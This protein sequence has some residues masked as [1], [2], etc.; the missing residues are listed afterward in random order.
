MR[1]IGNKLN[2]LEFIYSV[3]V[4]NK[5]PKGTLLDIFSG[6]TNVSKFFK[7]KGYK[8]ISND[9]MT[10]SYVF[11]RAYICNN[12]IPSFRGLSNEIKNPDIFKVISF[13]NELKGKEGFIFNNY[14]MEGTKDKD[15]QRN[16]FSENNAK[17]IDAIRDKIQDWKDNKKIT[18]DEF[19]I[20]LCSLLEVVPSVSN[21]AGTYGA[22]MKIDDPRKF[23]PLLLEVPTLIESDLKHECYN[24]DSNEL[25]KEVSC[26]ILYI[27]PP[28]NNRQYATNYHILET[29]AVWDK[30]ILNNKTG[31]RPYE[32]QKSKYCYSPKCIDVF[33]DLIN[34]AKCK[35]ILLSYNTE[36]IIP[37]NEVSR[38]LKN[39]GDVKVYKKEYRRYKSNSNGNSKKKSLNELIFFV[40]VRN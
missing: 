9:F 31:L 11:E 8:I 10:Y 15:F 39:K 34:N 38:I 24:K 13:L 25:I 22:F 18:E 14:C 33:E 26:D 4:E 7:K 36:G 16:Y 2:L 1:Y 5:L 23:K 3:I 27:D 28:Y 12:K 32:K 30:Q 20:L 35:F 6:T 17:K 40:K 29:I 21:V 19:F 37:Y